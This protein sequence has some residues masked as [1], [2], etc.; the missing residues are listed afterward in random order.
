MDLDG[1]NLAKQGAERYE[2]DFDHRQQFFHG[3][4]SNQL[5]VFATDGCLELLSM[6]MPH[7]NVSEQVYTIPVNH[8]QVNFNMAA[9]AITQNLYKEDSSQSESDSALTRF[10]A[11]GNI[12]AIVPFEEV[13]RSDAGD[14][15]VEL[16]TNY[17]VEINENN[18][19][20]PLKLKNTV[21]KM[22][23]YKGFE[24]LLTIFGVVRHKDNKGKPVKVTELMEFFGLVRDITLKDKEGIESF[25][26]LAGLEL[27]RS[28]DLS[29][30]NIHNVKNKITKVIR[31]LSDF[32]GSVLEGSHR[33]TVV[34]MLSNGVFYPDH[35]GIKQDVAS[36]TIPN[37]PDDSA[38]YLKTRFDVY[39]MDSSQSFT[40]AVQQV[41]RESY[42]KAKHQ[43]GTMNTHRK[44]E[45][46]SIV[47]SLQHCGELSDLS[48]SFFHSKEQYVDNKNVLASMLVT[49]FEHESDLKVAELSKMVTSSGD[50][51]VQTQINDL[52]NTILKKAGKTYKNAMTTALK[53]AG[54]TNMDTLTTIQLLLNAICCPE[55]MIHL[56]RYLSMAIPA[57]VT[58]RQRTDQ[59]EGYLSQS[60][61]TLYRDF[62]YMYVFFIEN[63]IKIF[64]RFFECFHQQSL[65]HRLIKPT[66]YSDSGNIKLT[67]LERNR[68][69]HECWFRSIFQGLFM[70]LINTYGEDMLFQDPVLRF[71]VE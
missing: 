44:D 11:G 50:A 3:A 54:S 30:Q 23:T 37:I 19:C 70:E 24:S 61:R 9:E 13:K 47:Q 28:E 33:M 64:P 62:Q 5:K 48:Q 34:A 55:H 71:I 59:A 66:G 56:R 27:S 6:L 21:G 51:S 2:L 69:F 29:P 10:D 7:G 41:Q 26:S 8:R 31:Y 43:A 14:D 40:E 63:V 39:M 15:Y 53:K 20:V 68:G 57:R 67:S 22:L 32:R 60:S 52:V 12:I 16:I 4:T 35:C 1:Y 36:S 25:C 65:K 17:S 38:L 18:S 42:D 58:Q 49:V 45:L 46:A